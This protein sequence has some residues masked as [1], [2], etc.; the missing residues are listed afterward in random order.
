MVMAGSLLLLLYASKFKIS[1]FQHS[2]YIARVASNYLRG[3]V[4]G[5]WEW[6][7]R[8]SHWLMLE[9]LQI[10]Q[11]LA[12]SNGIPSRPANLCKIHL[13][14]LTAPVAPRCPSCRKNSAFIS[15]LD[16]KLIAYESVFMVTGWPIEIASDIDY[17]WL[18][19]RVS[20]TTN[21]TSSKVYSSQPVLLCYQVCDLANIIAK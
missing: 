6:M 18:F 19:S 2:I 15:P 17:I 9:K 3:K 7:P 5:I 21:V 20:L 10:E 12:W 8:S 13:V 11:D 14:K 16:Q 1:L 4:F